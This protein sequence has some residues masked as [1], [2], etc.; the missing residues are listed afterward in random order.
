MTLH[1]ART[2]K[3]DARAEHS[4]RLQVLSSDRQ[5]QL[6]DLQLDRRVGRVMASATSSPCVK[7]LFRL[8]SVIQM[9]TKT[10]EVIT[11]SFISGGSL[12]YRL[13]LPAVVM[14]LE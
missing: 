6:Y 1:T 8:C 3:E 14:V 5:R 12:L 2:T 11:A 4:L 9:S 10:T 7:P 13:Q